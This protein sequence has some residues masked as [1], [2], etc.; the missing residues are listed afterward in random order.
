MNETVSLR[1]NLRD[2]MND[3]ALTAKGGRTLA[4]SLNKNVDLFFL[5]G[6]SRGKDIE[7]Q[8][9][10]AFNEN[11]E[12]ALR[13]LQWTRDVRGGAGERE[14]FRKLFRALLEARGQTAGR[15]ILQK[16]PEIGRW[17]DVLVAFGTVMERDA[18]EMIAKA[19]NSGAEA[20]SLL[21]KLDAMTEEEC[22]VMLEKIGSD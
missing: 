10:A 18:L 6:A 22:A 4:S 1:D 13:I 8:F 2:A 21:E 17:D 20:K 11:S 9:L 15:V 19:L 3:Q 14:T 5:A 7:P 12:V 16:V